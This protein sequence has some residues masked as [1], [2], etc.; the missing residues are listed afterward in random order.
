MPIEIVE[1]PK[2][3]KDFLLAL[4]VGENFPIEKKKRKAWA[5]LIS[6]YH[7]VSDRK[8][9]ISEIDGEIKVWRLK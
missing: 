7:G 8:W 3:R 4:G 1:V 2:K 6:V 9:T 5:S